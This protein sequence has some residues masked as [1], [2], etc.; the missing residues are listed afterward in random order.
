[1]AADNKLMAV[2]VTT[3]GARVNK[4]TA[5]PLFSPKR[6]G[7]RSFYDISADGQRFLVNAADSAAEITLVVNWAAGLKK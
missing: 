7:S 1:L 2:N 6:A 3:D 4:G 5:T